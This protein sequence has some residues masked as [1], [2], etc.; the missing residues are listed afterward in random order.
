MTT[1]QSQNAHEFI[2]HIQKLAIRKVTLSSGLQKLNKNGFKTI[3]VIMKV[4]SSDVLPH[5]QAKK[6]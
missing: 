1:M 4:C 6:C 5:Q 2:E 3:I